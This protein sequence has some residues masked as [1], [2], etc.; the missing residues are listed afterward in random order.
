MASVDHAP[1]P[2]LGHSGLSSGRPS[3]PIN[4]IRVPIMAI[5]VPIMAIRVTAGYRRAVRPHDGGRCPN[6]AV[7]RNAADALRCAAGWRAACRLGGTLREGVDAVPVPAS[8]HPWGCRPD[9]KA[10]DAR[11]ES[12]PGGRPARTAVRHPR[13]LVALA[14]LLLLVLPHLTL[15]RLP[16]PLLEHDCQYPQG[17]T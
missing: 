13:A 15:L 17:E 3:V 2:S 5:R 8:I 9:F 12:E 11:H 16:V 14:R 7:M 4:A 10:P 6:A 1:T